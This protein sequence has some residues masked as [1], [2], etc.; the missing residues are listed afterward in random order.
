MPFQRL[1]KAISRLKFT[2]KPLD[3]VAMA[4]LWTRL[5]SLV[6]DWLAMNFQMAFAG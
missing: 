2:K 6:V 1:L 3:W 4:R 5:G